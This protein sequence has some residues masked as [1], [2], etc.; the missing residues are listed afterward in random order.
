MKRFNL[1]GPP[2][3]LFFGPDG[4]ERPNYRVVGYMKAGP[5]R[6]VVKKATS[7]VTALRLSG[8]PRPPREDGVEAADTRDWKS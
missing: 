7:G 8:A 3:I 2:A 1:F 5:F 4:R 6:E